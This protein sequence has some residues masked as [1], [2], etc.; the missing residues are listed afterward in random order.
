MRKTT[1]AYRMGREDYLYP[2]EQRSKCPFVAGTVEQL[3]Y[4]DGRV[5][6]ARDLA[7]GKINL[8]AF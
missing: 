7:E 8:E 4:V 6:A 3:S 2:S 1:E 5:D